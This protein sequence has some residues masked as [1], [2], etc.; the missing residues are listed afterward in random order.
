MSPVKYELIQSRDLQNLSKAG[1]QITYP[2]E[3]VISE[4]RYHT[5]LFGREPQIN[6]IKV[7]GNGRV[8]IS[9]IFNEII[10]EFKFDQEDDSIVIRNAQTGQVLTLNYYPETA[11]P[12]RQLTP[13]EIES[14][15]NYK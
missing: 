3:D 15:K 5:F 13:K 7:F 12:T 4:N 1:L 11:L 8:R 14:L 2:V 9:D 6:K 10:D